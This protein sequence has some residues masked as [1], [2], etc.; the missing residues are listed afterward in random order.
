MPSI[1]VPPVTATWLPFPTDVPTF[2][3]MLPAAREDCVTI[4]M[5]PLVS[6][7]SPDDRRT[8]PE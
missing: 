3:K 6:D 5:F 1:E 4:V 8:P 7:P 2:S